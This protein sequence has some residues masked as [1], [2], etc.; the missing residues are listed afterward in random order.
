MDL[1]NSAAK[2]IARKER[3]LPIFGKVIT[4][5][6]KKKKMLKKLC[7]CVRIYVYFGNWKQIKQ[8]DN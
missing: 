8:I 2:K 4:L 6:R 3:V 7:I 5:F 1:K